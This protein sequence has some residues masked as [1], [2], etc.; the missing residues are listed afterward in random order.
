VEKSWSSRDTIKFS[1]LPGFIRRVKCGALT[2]WFYAVGDQE[3]V[4]DHVFPEGFQDDPV[5]RFGRKFVVE[6]DEELPVI[7]TC[8]GCRIIEGKEDVYPHMPYIYRVIFWDD[9]TTWNERHQ[10]QITLRQPPRPLADNELWIDEAMRKFRKLLAGKS[11]KFDIS[12][13]GGDKFVGRVIRAKVRKP[14]AEGRYYAVLHLK[15]EKKVRE[16][17]FD[18][19]PTPEMPDVITL[20]EKNMA[21]KGLTIQRVQVKDLVI[22]PKG[23]KWSGVFFSQPST[24]STVG[25][26]SSAV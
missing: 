24:N 4:G 18:F 15:E 8:M 14:S 19:K 21:K 6:G 11:T 3:L 9:G 12:F 10:N 1:K 25:V 22:T 5:Y 7:K 13:L 16:G 17:W 2:P 26:D 23:K 20:L